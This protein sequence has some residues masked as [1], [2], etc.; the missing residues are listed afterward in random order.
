M[1]D[2]HERH[3]GRPALVTPFLPR[4]RH[5]NVALALRRADQHCLSFTGRAFGGR[6]RANPSTA[7]ATEQEPLPTP[8]SDRLLATSR[9]PSRTDHPAADR[10]VLLSHPMR[11]SRARL[12]ELLKAAA[13]DGSRR[14][15]ALEHLATPV[16]RRSE[17]IARA[18]NPTVSPVASYL[19]SLSMREPN[20]GHL[21]R[22]RQSV[23]TTSSSDSASPESAGLGY[24]QQPDR[25]VLHLRNAAARNLPRGALERSA[26]AAHPGDAGVSALR[27]GGLL[28]FLTSSI[29]QLD[30]CIA[31]GEEQECQPSARACSLQAQDR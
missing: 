20:I 8:S 18:G 30:C 29:E 12:P 4:R 28:R 31:T 2:E 27:I 5:R 19:C 6:R 15:A 16:R 21:S 7:V 11:A 1:A 9:W 25:R 24:K 10:A 3:A 13:R 22:L 23:W 17:A 14:V 26:T